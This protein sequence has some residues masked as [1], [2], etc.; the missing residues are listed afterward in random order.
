MQRKEECQGAV[1][2]DPRLAVVSQHVAEKRGLAATV[3]PP[4]GHVVRPRH[5]VVFARW[6]DTCHVGDRHVQNGKQCPR[7]AHQ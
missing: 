6:S 3:H 1:V 4:V 5:H 7:A 2:I